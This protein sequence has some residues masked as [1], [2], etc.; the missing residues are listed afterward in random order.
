MLSALNSPLA[1][2]A[3][4][5]D[6]LSFLQNKITESELGQALITDINSK[7]VA[8]EVDAAIDDAKS[9]ATNRE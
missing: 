3:T 5:R 9:Q 2:T 4:T 7:A 1:T 6:V 8:T